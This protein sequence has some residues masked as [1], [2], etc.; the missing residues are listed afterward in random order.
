MLSLSGAIDHNCH[1]GNLACLILSAPCSWLTAHDCAACV[2]LR[3]LF[4]LGK[5]TRSV[6]TSCVQ[7]EADGSAVLVSPHFCTSSL[8]L[9]SPPFCPAGVY[10]QCL[11]AYAVLFRFGLQI[12]LQHH[13]LNLCSLFTLLFFCQ[14]HSKSEPLFPLT[15]LSRSVPSL[16][17][18]FTS[19]KWF[20]YCS[21]NVFPS[22]T[23][24]LQE[25]KVFE[26]W[27]Y[28]A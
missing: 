16:F 5:H 25:L 19:L 4:P 2:S 3:D 23:K 20:K 13:S 14:I 10:T 18:F 24:V 15:Q 9:L 26:I 12:K 17:Y 27:L 22:V 28:T 7:L 11:L 1:V 21:K 8:C 6:Q